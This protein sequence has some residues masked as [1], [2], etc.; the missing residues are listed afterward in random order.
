[1]ECCQCLGGL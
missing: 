1:M